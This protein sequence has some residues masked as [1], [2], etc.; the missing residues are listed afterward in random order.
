MKIQ[1]I[2]E[3]T[4]YLEHLRGAK[5]MVNNGPLT[6]PQ[7]VINQHLLGV[8]LCTSGLISWILQLMPARTSA[9]GALPGL[10][11]VGF[12][13]QILAMPNLCLSKLL[14]CLYNFE[15][16]ECLIS[17]AH[18]LSWFISC[19]LFCSWKSWYE[20]I[21]AFPSCIS[22]H[23][24]TSNLYLQTL[25]LP[26][27]RWAATIQVLRRVDLSTSGGGPPCSINKASP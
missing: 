15:L 4:T 9:G 6:N 1:K 16:L 19:V 3:T 7:G 21:H 8:P 22:F 11:C 2:F 23:V 18:D 5:W 25:C 27:G 26:A 14:I 10:R 13:P 17:L 24:C 12:F 20:F